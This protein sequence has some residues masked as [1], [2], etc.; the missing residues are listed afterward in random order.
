MTVSTLFTYVRYQISDEKNVSYT[1]DELLGYLNQ[2]N[3]YVYSVLMNHEVDLAMKK[4][5]LTLTD[6][7]GSL[8]SDFEFESAVKDENDSYLDSIQ[9]TATPNTSQYCILNQTLYSDNPTVTLFYFY[10]GNDYSLTDTLV[11]PKYF[12]NFFIQMVKFLVMNT[13]EYNMS[14]EQSLMVRFENQI[15]DITAKRSNS[16]PVAPMP[17][18]L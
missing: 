14:V 10:M 9:P 18:K 5:L 11:T 13:D 1:D 8:P 7:E 6:G 15:L 2:T 12:D 3:S 17:F 16:L 4:T